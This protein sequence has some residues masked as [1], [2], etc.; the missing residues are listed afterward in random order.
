ML[1]QADIALDTVV[2]PGPSV[3]S[4]KESVKAAL[5]LTRD[6]I[7]TGS[8]LVDPS[9]AT[10]LGAKGGNAT[11]ANKGP[12]YFKQISAMRKKKAG[13]RPKKAE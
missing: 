13:G 4:A 12:E 5:T 6:I 1:D 2:D 3:R 11:L 8:A 9:A 7:A 10:A